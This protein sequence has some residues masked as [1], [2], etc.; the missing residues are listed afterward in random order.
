MPRRDDL[1]TI[2]VLGSGPIKIGQAAE[3]EVEICHSSRCFGCLRWPCSPGF[4]TLQEACSQ[5]LAGAATR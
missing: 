3:F 2:L 1:K 4:A 5:A